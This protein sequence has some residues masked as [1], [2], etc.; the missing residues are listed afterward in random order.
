[1]RTLFEYSVL[2]YIMQRMVGMGA[3]D[4]KVVSG[5]ASYPLHNSFIYLFSDQIQ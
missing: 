3:D 4:A 5:E 1:M 2:Y